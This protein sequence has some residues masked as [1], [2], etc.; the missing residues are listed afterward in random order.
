M[1]KIDG[2]KHDAI[3]DLTN[4]VLDDIFIDDTNHPVIRELPTKDQKDITEIDE[5]IFQE[6]KKGVNLFSKNENKHMFRLL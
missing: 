3:V 2:L 5:E 4:N 6:K 1:H